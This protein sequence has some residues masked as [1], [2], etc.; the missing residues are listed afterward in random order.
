MAH[1]IF[2]V[3]Q[4]PGENEADRHEDHEG[5]IGTIVD[6]ARGRVQVLA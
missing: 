5:D 2:R 1:D 4:G 3:D 6:L